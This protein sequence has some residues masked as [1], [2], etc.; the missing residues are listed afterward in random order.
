MSSGPRELKWWNRLS[1]LW[2]VLLIGLGALTRDLRL[3]GIVLLVGGLIQAVF[4]AIVFANRRGLADRLAEY[5]AHRP[6]MLGGFFLN[7]LAGAQRAQG[8]AMLV[9]GVVLALLGIALM[10]R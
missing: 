6:R 2:F 1:V 4:G 5:Y 7:R 9:A 3:G 8:G 10:L